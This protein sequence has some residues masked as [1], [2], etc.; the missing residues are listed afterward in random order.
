MIKL[1]IFIFF[2]ITDST[3][4]LYSNQN[5]FPYSLFF[6]LSFFLFICFAFFVCLLACLFLPPPRWRCTRCVGGGGPS[7][8]AA[9]PATWR[10]SRG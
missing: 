10:T 1:L 2:I 7:A 8:S 9:P 5:Q 4:Y 3:K 6:F